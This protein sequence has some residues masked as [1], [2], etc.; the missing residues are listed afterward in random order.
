MDQTARII[1]THNEKDLE[2]I[3]SGIAALGALAIGITAGIGAWFG[4]AV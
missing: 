4:T 2:D 1:V 3:E